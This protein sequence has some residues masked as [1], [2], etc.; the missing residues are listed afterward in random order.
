MMNTSHAWLTVSVAFLIVA[1][2]IPLGNALDTNSEPTPETLEHEATADEEGVQALEEDTSLTV[3]TDT[4]QACE[5]VQIGADAPMLDTCPEKDQDVETSADPTSSGLDLELT[6]AESF[7]TPRKLAGFYDAKAGATDTVRVHQFGAVAGMTHDGEETWYRPSLSFFE[8][9]GTEPTK[10]PIVFIGAVPLDPFAWEEGQPVAAGDLTGD[11]AD[12]VAIAHLDPTN[13]EGWVTVL[14]GATGNTL[15]H[16]LLDGAAT[17]LVIHD[18]RLLL[19]HETGDLADSTHGVGQDGTTSELKALSFDETE[20]ELEASTEWI[21]DSEASWARWLDV[22]PIDDA[23]VVSLTDKPLGADGDAGTILHIE[24]DGTIAWETTTPE[25][26]RQLV[27]DSTRD[28]VVAHLYQDPADD[29]VTVEDTNRELSVPAG[30]TTL[31]A[32]RIASFEVSSGDLAHE[33][34]HE[35]RFLLDLDVA[36]V[37]DPDGAEWIT[38]DVEVLHNRPIGTNVQAVSPEDSP[39]TLWSQHQSDEL[40]PVYDLESLEDGRI[41][42]GGFDGFNLVATDLQALEGATGA[43]EWASQADFLPLFTALTDDEEGVLGASWNLALENVATSDGD[44]T[45]RAPIFANV[46]HSVSMDVTQD[47]EQDLV[48]GTGSQ[49]VFALDT[50]LS[51]PLEEHWM[52]FLPHPVTDLQR[53]D[54]TNDGADELVAPAGE[55]GVFILDPKTGAILDHVA[56]PDAYVWSVTVA[57][58]TEDGDNEVIVPTQSLASFSWDDQEDGLSQV[59]SWQ[60]EPHTDSYLS[61]VAITD[62]KVFV[63]TTLKPP[64]PLG[65]RHHQV[66]AALDGETGDEAWSHA[67]VIGY[68]SRAHLIDSV[69]VVP[70]QGLEGEDGAGDLVVFTY[71]SRTADASGFLANT[72]SGIEVLQTSLGVLAYDAT[73][74]EL[75]WGHGM[76]DIA[77]HQGQFVYEDRVYEHNWATTVGMDADDTTTVHLPSWVTEVVPMGGEDVLLTGAGTVQL[78]D[79]SVLTGDYDPGAP[80]AEWRGEL[81]TRAITPVVE[82]GDASRLVTHPW[83]MVNHGIVLGLQGTLF[84][85]I[86]L[87]PHGVVLVD[88][89]PGEAA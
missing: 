57:D 17:N 20:G 85:S 60:P 4:G 44:V 36:N 2:F 50:D 49:G 87:L 32:Y 84:S 25:Y 78:W 22:E 69:T 39:T 53:A 7:E 35:D 82:D 64:D 83:D 40:W 68:G 28:Q 56:F 72:D 63:Q 67:T 76:S 48:V 66:S 16:T 6:E 5:G 3:P 51:Y 81:S 13:L 24:G 80:P 34:K 21:Y 86:N 52:T 8:D 9:W 10:A 1:G 73:S 88:I 12:E 18:G 26:P 59:W 31:Y 77:T 42:A 89:E 54:V 30:S 23:Y 65:P 45:F 61:E 74:G 29:S 11:G 62:G 70:N 55:E 47:D 27:D 71:H 37:G 41:L 43:T 58:V 46:G 75:V 19:A 79:P 14:D 38:S 33:V 15:W